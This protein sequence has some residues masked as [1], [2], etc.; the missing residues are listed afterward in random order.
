MASTAS[1]A[2][3]KQYAH[4]RRNFRLFVLDYVAFGIAYGMVGANSALIPNFVS[5]LTNNK[6]IIGLATAMY[7]FSWLLPQLFLAQW[8][9][10]RA[11]RQPFMRPA[12]VFR[13]LMIII[14]ATA[15]FFGAENTEL[16]LVVFCIGYWLFA[17]GDSIVTLAWMDLLGSSIPNKLRGT[18]FGIGQ[19]AVAIGALIMSQFARWAVGDSGLAFPLNYAIVFIVAGLFF[20][21]GGIGLALIREEKNEIP[22]TTALPTRQYAVFLGN[23]LKT[24]KEFRKFIRTRLL[25]DFAAMS[26]PFY[27]VFATNQ[28]GLRDAAVIGDNII[29]FQIGNMLG[30]VMM[31][32]LSRRSGSRAVI[33]MAA[34]AFTIEPLLALISTAGGGQT[35]IYGAFLLVG[36]VA[37]TATPSYFDWIITHAPPHSRPIYIGLTNTISAV[38]NLAP[39]L[40][41]VLLQLTARAALPPLDGFI[42]DYLNI[43]SHGITQYPIVFSLSVILAGLGLLSALRLH[44]PRTK[45]A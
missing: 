10:S 35:A 26:I 43:S 19:F 6:T 28:L 44:E 3:M 25:L 13:L 17:A 39:L 2:P 34:L 1:A 30:A 42:P 23:V 7:T 37:S 16:I 24:D 18:M 9:N 41:G 38:S 27:T 4:L 32:L 14:G 40:G 36:L 8:V 45:A 11:R 5:Q 22:P 20:V 21:S 31:S 15:A 12:P 29:L 33:I